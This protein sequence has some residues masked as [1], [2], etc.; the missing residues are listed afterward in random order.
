[1]QIGFGACVGKGSH[2]GQDLGLGSNGVSRRVFE[3]GQAMEQQLLHH[4]NDANA[5]METVL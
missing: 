3:V 5:Q 2:C 4:A 1:M